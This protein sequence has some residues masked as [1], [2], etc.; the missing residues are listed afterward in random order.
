MDNKPQ[1]N[2]LG[3][4]LQLCG[5]NPNTGFFRDGFSFTKQQGNDLSTPNL[6]HQFP[7]LKEGDRWCLCISRW[8]EAMKVQKAPPVV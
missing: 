7:G 8:I 3:T 2:V 5:C 4:D 1:K 6:E